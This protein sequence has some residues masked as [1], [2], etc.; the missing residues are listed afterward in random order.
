MKLCMPGMNPNLCILRM[1]EDIFS[2]DKAYVSD[3]VTGAQH[4]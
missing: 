2:L 3:K 4:E 1:L